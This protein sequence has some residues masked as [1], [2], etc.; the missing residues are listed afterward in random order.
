MGFDIFGLMLVA[1]IIRMEF[2]GSALWGVVR[3]GDVMSF[4]V[5]V[6]ARIS[7]I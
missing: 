2:Y 6:M 7:H 5:I 4:M 1:V 3:F